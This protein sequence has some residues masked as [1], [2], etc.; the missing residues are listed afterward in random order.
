MNCKHY[1][2]T[3][4]PLLSNWLQFH[5]VGTRV[6]EYWQITIFVNSISSKD[7]IVVK[8][9]NSDLIKHKISTVASNVSKTMVGSTQQSTLYSISNIVTVVRLHQIESIS[10]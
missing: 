4:G 1:D 8:F 6:P 3:Q 2:Q 9:V 7:K 5:A 10:L